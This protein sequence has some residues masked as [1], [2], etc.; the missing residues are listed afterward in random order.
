M[1]ATL[2]RLKRKTGQ[3]SKNR[4]HVEE[5]VATLTR[6]K[7]RSSWFAPPGEYSGRGGGDSDEIETMPGSISPGTIISGRGGGDS[8]EIETRKG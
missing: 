7:R 1:V 4:L 6:L 3:R 8:D 2:T 5:V